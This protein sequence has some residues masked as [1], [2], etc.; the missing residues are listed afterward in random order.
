MI[1]AIG[2]LGVLAV[3][4]GG[5]SGSGDATPTSGAAVSGSSDTTPNLV[6]QASSP[7]KAGG[8]LVVALEAETDGWDPT[9]NRWANSGTEVALAIYDPLAMLD[10]NLQ[11]KPYL[12]ESI[13]SS[14]DFKTWTIKLRPNITFHDGSPLNADAIKTFLDAFKASALTGAAARPIS[15]I[16]V[17]DDLTIK[18]GMSEAWSTFPAFLTGQGGVIP[19]P[20][21]LADPT[22]GPRHPVGTGPFVF[23]DWAPDNHLNVSK[24]TNYWRKAEGLPYLDSVEF[25][26]IPDTSSRYNALKAGD[27]SLLISSQ[28]ATI[29][30]LLQDGKDGRFQVTRSQGDNDVNTL[31]INTTK[32]PFDDLRVRQALAYGIDREALNQITETDP[33]L[34][35]DS[36]Y[37]KDSKWYA[38]TD[39]PSYDQAKAKA[40]IADYE[41]DKGP[42]TFA[43]GG[44]TDPD[45]VKAQQAIAQQWSSLGITIEQK[46][47]EQATFILNA[48]TGNY[49]IQ[50]WRQFGASDPDLNYTWWI[51][52]NATGPLALNMA[53]N[54]DP[55]IDAALRAGRATLDDAARKQAY[56]DI[57]KRQTV[58]L[59]YIWLSHLRWA[60][61]ADNHVRGIEGVKLP[62]G[63]Q[64]AGLVSG[65]IALT[66]MWIEN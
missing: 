66:G 40:L 60:M 9:Q 64:S 15:T 34:A 35:A 24:N 49:Q 31:L 23:G 53:R 48:I 17:V 47:F 2:F 19:S 8:K 61:A 5:S 12:A 51:G 26:P 27:V 46:S 16:D 37:A 30:N 7:P 13:T 59:P 44:T 43:F 63:T 28:E 42:L 52:E 62:D 65:V 21:M 32:A 56:T 25:R 58:D 57:A 6:K 22:N 54:Q 10:V 41:K 33:S 18:L 20:K 39:F 29:T 1:A 55:Q 38:N 11:P 45:V 3:G 36:V 4:C 14:P 50:L